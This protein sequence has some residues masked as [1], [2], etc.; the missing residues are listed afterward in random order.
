MYFSKAIPPGDDG[1]LFVH[2]TEE[3]ARV[4]RDKDDGKHTP[5]VLNFNREIEEIRTEHRGYG[6]IFRTIT[7]APP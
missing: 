2:L 4:L 3:G 5:E 1:I 7:F 6:H